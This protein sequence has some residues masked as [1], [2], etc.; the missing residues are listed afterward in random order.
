MNLA[1]LLLFIWALKTPKITTLLKNGA[2]AMLISV[3]FLPVLMAHLFGSPMSGYASTSQLLSIETILSLL[4]NP[5]T[6]TAA[7]LLS[8]AR[9]DR[10]IAKKLNLSNQQK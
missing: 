6:I 9:S 4:I 7:V 8:W 3:N 10:L 1:A 2:A 5:V